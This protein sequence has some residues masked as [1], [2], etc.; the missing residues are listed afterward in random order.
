MWLFI[1]IGAVLMIL[2]MAN[3][4]FS[5]AFVQLSYVMLVVAMLAVLMGVVMTATSDP[6]KMIGSL[7]GVVAVL[8]I[9]GVSYALASG[10]VLEEQAKKGVTETASRMSGAGLF[11]FYILLLGAIGS[12]I[13]ASVSRL[14]K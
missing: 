2:T 1:I 5:G 3:Y 4:E 9:F 8:V 11:M 6:K 12:I 7:I 14:F 10:D 13:Y